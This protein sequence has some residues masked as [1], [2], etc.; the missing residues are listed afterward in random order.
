[1][2][3]F[4]P[5]LVWCLSC[6]SSHPSIIKAAV[7]LIPVRKFPYDMLPGKSDI[8]RRVMGSCNECVA[9]KSKFQR[10][11]KQHLPPDP[12]NEHLVY[13]VQQ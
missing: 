4:N 11:T 10:D 12:N 5:D 8:D 13:R 9:D 1:M 7:F 6:K 3:K 2:S